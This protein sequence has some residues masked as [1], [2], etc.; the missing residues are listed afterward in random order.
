MIQKTLNSQEPEMINKDVL[1]RL[2]K[3]EP[4]LD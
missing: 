3:L 1:V 4:Y 2:D